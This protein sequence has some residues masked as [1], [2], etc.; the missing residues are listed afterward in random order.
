MSQKLV[1]LT[2]KQ[3]AD[4]LGRTPNAIRVQMER[5]IINIGYVEPA[6]TG[7]GQR[8]NYIIYQHLVDEYARKV[9]AVEA[10]N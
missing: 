2:V 8:K 4:L 3:A 9:R 7:T 10:I 1:R 6:L 5:G